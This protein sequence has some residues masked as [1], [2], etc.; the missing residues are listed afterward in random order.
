M[1]FPLITN[2]PLRLALLF[3]SP[4]IELIKDFWLLPKFVSTDELRESIAAVAHLSQFRFMQVPRGKKMKVAMTNCGPLGWTSSTKGYAYLPKDPLTDIPWP[5]MP[6]HFNLLCANAL[7]VVG[8]PVVQPDAC[9][10]NRY[11]DGAGMGLHCDQD[12]RDLTQPI[13]SVSI[14]DSCKFMLGGL[15]R[16]SPV[17]SIELHDGDVMVW[18][19]SA[20]LTYHGVRPLAENTERYNLTFR[21]AG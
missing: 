4:P 19:K 13:V 17:R 9:L 3:S 2:S 12:E 8:W 15:Q 1:S 7:A 11:G 10:I 6:S 5:A 14:G 16:S 18:G 21:K 20:R